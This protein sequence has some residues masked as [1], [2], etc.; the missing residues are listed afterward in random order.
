MEEIEI[1]KAVSKAMEGYVEPVFWHVTKEHGWRAIKDHPE[2]PDLKYDTENLYVNDEHGFFPA[3]F[4]EEIMEGV[5]KLN[6]RVVSEEDFD[7]LK[8]L[9]LDD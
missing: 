9:L 7:D 3:Q 8:K 6:S 2:L 5:D 4:Y 1:E